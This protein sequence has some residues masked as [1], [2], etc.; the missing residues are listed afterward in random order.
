MDMEDLIKRTLD[1]DNEEGAS[2]GTTLI[3]PIPTP[4]TSLTTVSKRH[5][6]V[7]VS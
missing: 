5:A 3:S 1:E 6:E 7:K 4:P 2:N